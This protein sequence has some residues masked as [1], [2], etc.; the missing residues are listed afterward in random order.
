MRTTDH[1]SGPRQLLFL[2]LHLHDMVLMTL[3]L[4]QFRK[5]RAF[6]PAFLSWEVRSWM[7]DLRLM[8]LQG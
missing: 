2:T 3:A 8:Q 5:E 1:A 4:P 7:Q 6:S